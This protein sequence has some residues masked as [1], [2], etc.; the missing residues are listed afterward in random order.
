MTF[1]ETNAGAASELDML[2]TLAG[3]MREAAGRV[4]V[5]QESAI[6]LLIIALLARGHVLLEGVPGDRKSTR[7]NSSHIRRSRMPSS[8]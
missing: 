1:P 2:Q 8:A 5:G 3:Q 4:L 6:E 7:L